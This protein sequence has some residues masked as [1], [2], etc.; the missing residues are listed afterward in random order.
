MCPHYATRHTAAQRAQQKL[1][2]MGSK[3]T[4][5][6]CVSTLQVT[7]VGDFFQFIKNVCITK[8]S[9]I[10]SPGTEHLCTRKKYE[11]QFLITTQYSCSTK[12]SNTRISSVK[13]DTII[14]HKQSAVFNTTEMSVDEQSRHQCCAASML[15]GISV[16]Q[17]PLMGLTICRSNF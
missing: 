7:F 4:V 1:I 3:N 10:V 15:C 8:K 12:Q 11:R 13:T 6:E 2:S 14:T 9:V 16:A 17:L 5:H